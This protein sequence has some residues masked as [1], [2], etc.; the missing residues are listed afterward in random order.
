M[1][2]NTDNGAAKTVQK[3]GLLKA[4]EQ[5]LPGYRFQV[6]RNQGT[7][8]SQAIGEV[9]STALLGMLLAVLVL[10]VFLRRIGMTLIVSLSIS[11]SIVATFNHKAD[12]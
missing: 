10:F 9:K 1:D 7:F 11:I 2:K 3:G 5:A 4:M 12:C 6:I 8:I